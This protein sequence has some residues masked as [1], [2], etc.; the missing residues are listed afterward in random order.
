[1]KTKGNCV[2]CIWGNKKVV[3][4]EVIIDIGGDVNRKVVAMNGNNLY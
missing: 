4:Y 3:I 1:L 2:N